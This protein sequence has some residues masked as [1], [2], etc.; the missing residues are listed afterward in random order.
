MRPDPSPMNALRCEMDAMHE[1]IRMRIVAVLELAGRVKQSDANA[2]MLLTKAMREL[3]ASVRRHVTAE[4]REL[5][6]RIDALE[7]RLAELR[8][9]LAVEHANELGA[10]FQVDYYGSHRAMAEDARAVALQLEAALS[11]EETLVGA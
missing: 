5:G 4:E 9:H 10:I 7:P 11:T 6:P 3:A 2:A 8:N 1:D